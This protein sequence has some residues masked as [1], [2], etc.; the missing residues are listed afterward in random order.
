MSQD[1]D[2]RLVRELGMSIAP[3]DVAYV[4]GERRLEN[5]QIALP[6]LIAMSGWRVKDVA[7]A[8]RAARGDYP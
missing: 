6:E 5:G 8:V 7:R 3:G 2:E 1:D 4:P